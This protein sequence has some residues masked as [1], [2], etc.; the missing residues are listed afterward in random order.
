[1]AHWYGGSKIS[2]T[3]NSS[4]SSNSSSNN[5]NFGGSGLAVPPIT[6]IHT[7]DLYSPGH[8]NVHNP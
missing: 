1:M 7:N 5:N 4:N 6:F 3:G 2:K 8:L